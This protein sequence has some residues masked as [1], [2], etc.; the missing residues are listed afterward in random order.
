MF[1]LTGASMACVT[2][3]CSTP[4]RRSSRIIISPSAGDGCPVSSVNRY[5]A[6]SAITCFASG[7]NSPL[8]DT[9]TNGRLSLEKRTWFSASKVGIQITRPHPSV[10]QHHAPDGVGIQ[11]S[12]GELA[13]YR[14]C[15]Q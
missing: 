3:M 2:T 11:S 12:Y 5:L 4:W 7:T 14:H 13:P 6:A 8:R 1:I 10:I 9:A 15:R